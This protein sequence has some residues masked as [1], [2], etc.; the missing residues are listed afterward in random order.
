M[1]T[2]HL[3]LHLGGGSNPPSQPPVQPGIAGGIFSNVGGGSGNP[4]QNTPR[5]RGWPGCSFGRTSHHCNGTAVGHARHVGK[6]PCAQ[7][8]DNPCIQ[9][10]SPPASSTCTHRR[11][12][13]LHGERS[14]NDRK[15][16]VACYQ[17][18]ATTATVP[19]NPS[20]FPPIEKDFKTNP[21]HTREFSFVGFPLLSLLFAVA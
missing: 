21:L 17:K 7:C 4:T 10:S 12:H 18:R 16:E 11:R 13:H 1:T 8:Y 2:A 6:E 19:S 5:S 20:R 9:C 14:D 15:H 3:D